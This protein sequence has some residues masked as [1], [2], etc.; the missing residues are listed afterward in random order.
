MSSLVLAEILVQ[1]TGKDLMGIIVQCPML[2]RSWR[3]LIHRE[4]NGLCAG[5][6]EPHSLEWL[7]LGSLLGILRRG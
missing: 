5:K 7:L 2:W 6:V 1:T 3:E 4:E